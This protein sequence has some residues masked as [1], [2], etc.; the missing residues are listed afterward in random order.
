MAADDGARELPR[1]SEAGSGE[2]AEAAAEAT[3]E[4]G[5]SADGATSPGHVT[6]AD[7]S[8]AASAAASASGVRSKMPTG[9]TRTLVGTPLYM[10]PEVMRGESYGYAA[11]WWAAVSALCPP[12]CHVLLWPCSGRP[13]LWHV[14][15]R[16]GRA[17]GVLL[18]VL[19][20][21]EGVLL[22]WPRSGR[23]VACAAMC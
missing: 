21:A 16:Y 11:A 23:V 13:V 14:L 15:P 4:A 1:V 19:P 10:A 2:G 18:H 9:R 20:C 7:A 5:A 3:G 17:Q 22:L 8:S 6:A 12:L